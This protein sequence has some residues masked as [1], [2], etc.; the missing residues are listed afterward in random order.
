M[1]SSKAWRFQKYVFFL[2]SLDIL[3]VLQG[4]RIFENIFLTV[5]K[6]SWLLKKCLQDIFFVKKCLGISPRA[7]VEPSKARGFQKIGFGLLGDTWIF[8]KYF[9]RI[10]DGLWVNKKYFWESFK[11]QE[12]LKIF[13]CCPYEFKKNCVK[14]VPIGLWF[15]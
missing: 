15:F 11:V 10:R 1:D 14:D 5:L 6:D 13:C 4:P 12:F 3:L 8:F 2:V 7:L 9:L